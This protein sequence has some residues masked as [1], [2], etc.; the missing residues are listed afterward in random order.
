MA[1][2]TLTNATIKLAHSLGEQVHLRSIRDAFATLMPFFIIAGLMVLVNNVFLKPDNWLADIIGN[3][4]I[5][6]WRTVG[7]A[8]INGS[9]NFIGVL[10]AATV[11]W[12][13][14]LNKNHANPIA[15]VLLSVATVIVFMPD[16]ISAALVAGKENV[17]VTGVLSYSS[18][19][20][21]GMF[22][23][24]I[25]GLLVTTVFIRLLKSERLKITIA[26]DGSVPPAVIDSFNALIPVCITLLIFSLISFSAK[27]WLG[28]D[29]NALIALT[30]Q[31]P[32]KN[33]TTDLPGFLFIYTVGNLFF[34][35]GI[36][37]SVINA[38]ILRPGLL[39][40]MQENMLAYANGDDIPNI[41]N[42]AFQTTFGQIGGTGNTLALLL[43]LFIFSRRQASRNIAKISFFMG[44]FN[45]N[46]PVIFGLPIVFNPI[47][48]VPFILS[49]VI[50]LTLAWLVTLWGW[51]DPVVIQIPWTTPPLIS[52]FLATG[53]D[54]RA[55]VFQ[56]VIIVMM[57]MLY[58]PFI[59]LS[60]RVHTLNASD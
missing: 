59:K 38:S 42:Y 4:A 5:K 45:I 58:L 22:L 23:G 53:G 52:G 9:L 24:M 43:A 15:P 54:W 46:E 37:Q 30:I 6:S 33:I 8:I 48:I 11:S 16:T 7:E 18:T 55:V 32:L 29:I 50:S 44:L 26:N 17:Q 1:T 10:I 14:C 20:T 13:L 3:E 36:H 2:G 41:I 60:E 12:H 51:M 31:T 25:T 35:I 28:K 21:S 56:L 49:P 39:A 34:A 40:S 27:Y 57:V 47:L 19:G